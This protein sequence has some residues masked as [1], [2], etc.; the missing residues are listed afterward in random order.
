MLCKV[1][2]SEGVQS[3]QDGD[4]PQF[5]EEKLMRLLPSKTGQKKGGKDKEK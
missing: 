5:I 3:I 4:N 2:I 1:I